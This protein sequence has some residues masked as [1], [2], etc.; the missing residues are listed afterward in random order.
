MFNWVVMDVVRKGFQ[1]A[2]VIDRVFP[3]AALPDLSPHDA[4][5][6][7]VSWKCVHAKGIL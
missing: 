6:A 7:T 5:A 2:I 3:K 1:L 4:F